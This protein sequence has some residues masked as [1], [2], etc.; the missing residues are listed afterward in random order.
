MNNELKG[1]KDLQTQL[2]A[3]LE[4]AEKEIDG[5]RKE[6]AT[7]QARKDTLE[8]WLCELRDSLKQG[9]TIDNDAMANEVCEDKELQNTILGQ[10]CS[11]YADRI[12][13]LETH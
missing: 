12:T 6:S 10:K 2:L 8:E 11:D 13:E 1:I 3:R 9:N 7:F 4:K 5:L